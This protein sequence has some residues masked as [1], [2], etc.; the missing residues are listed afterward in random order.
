MPSVENKKQKVTVEKME[1]EV[2]E[3]YI[4][5]EPDSDEEKY[6]NE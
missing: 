2:E 5:E 4:I 1:V 3:H 6:I